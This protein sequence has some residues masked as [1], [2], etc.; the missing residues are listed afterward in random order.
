MN[1]K[2]CILASV[3]LIITLVPPTAAYAADYSDSIIVA[4]IDS[5]INREHPAFYGANIL[6]GRNLI[7]SLCGYCGRCGFCILNLTRPMDDTNDESG[8]GTYVAGIIVAT[9]GNAFETT[10]GAN[11]VAILPLR[12]ATGAANFIRYSAVAAAIYYAVEEGVHIIN[13]SLG[14]FVA[15]SAVR[16]AVD[17]AAANGVWMIAAVGNYGHINGGEASMYPANFAYV[18]GVGTIT[19]YG[20]RWY[21]SQQNNS[22]FVVMPGENILATGL[23][24][25]LSKEKGTSLSAPKIT[26]LAAI[27][28]AYNPD[29]SEAA[30]RYL[31]IDS[32]IPKGY[33]THDAYYRRVRNDQYGYGIVDFELF[34]YNLTRRDY[35]DFTDSEAGVPCI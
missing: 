24:D 3:L 28:R 11:G 35:L 13:I 32:A 7:V 18:I 21:R 23:N 1:K 12:V 17:H 10:S 33:P 22:V 34:M 2:I 26:A 19:G 30:F 25:Y 14:T 31:L 4:V 8:H 15:S 20:E 5:G 29:M 9:M 16:D 6:P 27:A